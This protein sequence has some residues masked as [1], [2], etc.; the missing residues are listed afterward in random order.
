MAE[1]SP[2]ARKAFYANQKTLCAKTKLAS[3]L[4]AHNA[5]VRE[6]ALSMG[7]THVAMM[8][9]N[10]MPWEPWHEWNTRTLRAARV[11]STLQQETHSTKHDQDYPEDQTELYLYYNRRRKGKTRRRHS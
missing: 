6:A 5:I 8:G 9:L 11:N 3:R 10:R 4:K 1:M 7:G 2:R